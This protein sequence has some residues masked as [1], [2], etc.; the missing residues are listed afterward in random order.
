MAIW[1]LLVPLFDEFNLQ[2][3]SRSQREL[4]ELNVALGP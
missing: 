3:A 2:R 1:V 4:D